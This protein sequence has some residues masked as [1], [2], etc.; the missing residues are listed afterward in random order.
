MSNKL[1]GALSLKLDGSEMSQE[2][3]IRGQ[4]GS[5][6]LWHEHHARPSLRHYACSAAALATVVLSLAAFP[7]DGVDDAAGP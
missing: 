1:G 2:V 4:Q 6:D 3:F 7:L 5:A